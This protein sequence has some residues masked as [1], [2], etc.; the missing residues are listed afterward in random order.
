MTGNSR[1]DAE[2]LVVLIPSEPAKIVS[3][4]IKEQVVYVGYGAVNRRRLSGAEFL[5]NLDK[6]FFGCSGGVLLKYCRRKSRV[7]VKVLAYLRVGA[8]S[9]STY[10]RCYRYLSVFIYANID[11]VV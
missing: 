11:D 9:Q 7:A 5:I 8:Y 10:E 3:S 2:L 1:C 6:S 4:R